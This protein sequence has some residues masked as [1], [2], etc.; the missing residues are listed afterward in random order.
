MQFWDLATFLAT[1][2]VCSKFLATFGQNFGDKFLSDL[3][4]LVGSKTRT[5]IYR[6]KTIQARLVNISKSGPNKTRGQRSNELSLADIFTRLACPAK[7]AD[8]STKFATSNNLQ[9][10]VVCLQEGKNF[11]PSPQDQHYKLIREEITPPQR[12]SPRDN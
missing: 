8:S 9:N 12:K 10:S 1:F 3:A 7:F 4:T 2:S 11:G 6:G 5:Q